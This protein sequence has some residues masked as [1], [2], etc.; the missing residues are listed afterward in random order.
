ML[1]TIQGALQNPVFWTF[2]FNLSLFCVEKDQIHNFM[3]R[4]SNIKQL[5]L[6]FYMQLHIIIGYLEIILTPNNISRKLWNLIYPITLEPFEIQYFHNILP[7]FQLRKLLWSI[8]NVQITH[9][10]VLNPFYSVQT[11]VKNNFLLKIL[12]YSYYYNFGT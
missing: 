6:W 11:C 9:F 1:L 2:F 7:I 3:W 4:D 8:S 10:V 5:E 12:Q